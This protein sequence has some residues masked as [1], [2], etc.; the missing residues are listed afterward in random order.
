M[1]FGHRD[2]HGNQQPAA[3]AEGLSWILHLDSRC[4]G[5]TKSVLPGVFSAY[6]QTDRNSTMVHRRRCRLMRGA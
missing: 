4:A 1:R 3:L 5:C 2:Q 6:Q